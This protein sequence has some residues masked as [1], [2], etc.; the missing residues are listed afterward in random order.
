VQV[1]FVIT[2][3]HWHMQKPMLSA[4]PGLPE[5][6]CGQ[7]VHAEDPTTSLYF[8]N[9]HHEHELYRNGYVVPFSH[10][11]SVMFTA[12]TEFVL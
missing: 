2:I 5:E 6:Y 7:S 3:P 10:S 8:P 12:P 9:S 11:Q 1:P 4:M